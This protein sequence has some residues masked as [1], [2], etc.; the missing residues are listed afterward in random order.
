MNWDWKADARS[1]EQA[2]EVD[3]SAPPHNDEP[4]RLAFIGGGLSTVHPYLGVL[5]VDHLA[6]PTI[7]GGIRA[8]DESGRTKNWYQLNIVTVKK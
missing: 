4:I 3:R 5:T 2:A 7:I 1:V 8:C 6:I